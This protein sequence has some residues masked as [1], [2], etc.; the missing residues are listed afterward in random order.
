MKKHQVNKKQTGAKI[1]RKLKDLGIT[2]DTLAELLNL[3]SSR[4]IYEWVNGNKLPSIE[5]LVT[6]TMNLN[7]KL[8]EL[9]VIEEIL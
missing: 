4:V 5:H 7:M 8:E 3:S 2:F 9:L 1:Y 6:I